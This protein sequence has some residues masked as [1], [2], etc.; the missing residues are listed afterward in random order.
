LNLDIV[1]NSFEYFVK[2]YFNWNIIIDRWEFY[3]QPR[4]EFVMLRTFNYRKHK[5]SLCLGIPFI[6]GE[7]FATQSTEPNNHHLFY[8]DIEKLRVFKT[9]KMPIIT[10]SAVRFQ[11]IKYLIV[12]MP[13]IRSSLWNN[14]SDIVKFSKTSDNDVAQQSVTY[15]SYFVQ[16]SHVSQIEFGS[17]FDI[18]RW[19]DV[20]FILQ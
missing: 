11:Q 13:I 16:L 15:L 2:K 17:T 14:L 12:E 9:K 6:Y 1:V 7:S 10:W 4:E 20:R 18:S 19:K 3:C 5:A 8:S